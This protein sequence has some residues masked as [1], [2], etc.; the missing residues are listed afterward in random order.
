MKDQKTLADYDRT[1]IY[2]M[3]VALEGMPKE[4]AKLG[5]RIKGIKIDVANDEMELKK[6]EGFVLQDLIMDDGSAYNK[7]G[8]AADRKVL[9]QAAQAD[10]KECTAQRKKIAGRKGMINKLEGE[11]EELSQ[12]RKVNYAILAAYHADV[13]RELKRE[14]VMTEFAK[15]PKGAIA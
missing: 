5:R 14:S 10:N 7:A 6:L 15:S 13:V 11:Y 12:T 3:A 9:L 2:K 1:A 4:L 8:N